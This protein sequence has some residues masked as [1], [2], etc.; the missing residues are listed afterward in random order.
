[1]SLKVL[2][3]MLLEK[4]KN[5]KSL[6]RSLGETARYALTSS[7][8]EKLKKVSESEKSTLIALRL[9]MFFDTTLH[10]KKFQ[11]TKTTT[12]QGNEPTTF[13]ICNC[14]FAKIKNFDFN[15]LIFIVYK[16]EYTDCAL[17][18]DLH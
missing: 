8:H 17:E 7:K 15:L 1:M 5:F 16:H 11:L 9:M 2:N 13:A 18:I 14:V 4:N 6:F 3:L 12:L 10:E